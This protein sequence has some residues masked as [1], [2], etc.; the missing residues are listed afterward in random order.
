LLCQ[1]VLFSLKFDS[2]QIIVSSGAARFLTPGTRKKQ[3]PPLTEIRC[4]KIVA[5]VYWISLYVSQLLK[6]CRVQKI[7]FIQI[8]ILL[9]LRP[10]CPGRPHH[11][12]HPSYASDCIT[13]LV[14]YCVLFLDDWLNGFWLFLYVII[15]I[16]RNIY[17]YVVKQFAFVGLLYKCKLFCIFGLES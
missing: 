10:C 2:C 16:L 3:W 7:F 12:P 13:L 6:I 1:I 11:S 8:L 15:R 17:T 9:L 14:M 4:I 5:I